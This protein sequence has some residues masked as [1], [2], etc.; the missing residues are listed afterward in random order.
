[1]QIELYPLGDDKERVEALLR[2]ILMVLIALA[3]KQGIQVKGAD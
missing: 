2:G 1:M 3:T